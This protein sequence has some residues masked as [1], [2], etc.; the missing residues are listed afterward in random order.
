MFRNMA[1]SLICAAV[2]DTAAPNTIKVAGRIITTVEKAKELRPVVE[3]LITMGKKALKHQD[4]AEQF[5]T[6]AARGS[7]E[8]N[9]WRNSDRWQQWAKAIAP[10][11]TFRRRAFAALRSKEAVKILFSDLA[12]RFRDREGGYTRIVRL[13][14]FRLGDAGRKALIEFVGNN[15]RKK[16]RRAAPTVN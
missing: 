12:P 10:A 6:A 9:E 4:A 7:A 2:P 15:D 13:A 14:E 11:V 1:T 16:A 8:W 3:K 5:A